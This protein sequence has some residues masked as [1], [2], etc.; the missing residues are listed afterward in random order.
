MNNIQTSAAKSWFKSTTCFDIDNW[1]EAL[2]RSPWSWNIKLWHPHFIFRRFHL[3]V[4]SI[5]THLVR[6]I[7]VIF[8]TNGCV[9]T[10]LLQAFSSVLGPRGLQ[11]MYRKG[12]KYLYIWAYIHIQDTF[13]F[14]SSW[15]FYSLATVRFIE[16]NIIL[17]SSYP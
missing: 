9:L 10:N 12:K 3:I 2:S 5:E 11:N 17:F 16:Q 14:V 1:K 6:M 13:K 7:S 4:H 15:V 8:T